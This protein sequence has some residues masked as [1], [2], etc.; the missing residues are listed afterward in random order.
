MAFRAITVPVQKVTNVSST[1]LGTDLVD[2]LNDWLNSP[3]KDWKKIRDGLQRNLNTTDEIE[4]LIETNNLELWQL[5]WHKWDLFDCYPKAEVALSNL[6]YERPKK[7]GIN[8]ANDLVRILAIFGD[9]KGIDI[10]KDRA[11]LEQ[12]SD[13]AYI[14]FLPEPTL[15][16]FH[17]KLWDQE[18]DILFFAGHSS[19]EDA[20]G[21]IYTNKDKNEYLTID[22]LKSWLD[23]AIQ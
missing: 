12:L 14:E 3:S 11:Y 2:S 5:P 19:S 21:R 7:L 22:S 23:T 18:W 1:Q 20:K 13:R 17:E 9:S 16:E 4:I 15:K 10:S 6:E 8:N